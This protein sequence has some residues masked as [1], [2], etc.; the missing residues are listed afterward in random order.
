MLIPLEDFDTCS[1]WAKYPGE[2]Y[3]AHLRLFCSSQRSPGRGI[4][5]PPALV[6]AA[7]LARC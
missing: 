5:V 3:Q 6:L 7:A 2:R 1:T 4:V